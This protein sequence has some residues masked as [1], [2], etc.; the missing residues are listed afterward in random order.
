MP[1]NLRYFTL[2]LISKKVLYYKSEKKAKALKSIG[3]FDSWEIEWVRPCE[4]DYV[5]IA[6]PWKYGIDL[7]VHKK[8]IRLITYSE[9]DR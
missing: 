2:D 4:I 1:W 6:N 7:F 9:I 3:G 5:K 8:E